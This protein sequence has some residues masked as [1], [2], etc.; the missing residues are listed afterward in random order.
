MPRFRFPVK[1]EDAYRLLVSCY[2]VEVDRRG[3]DFIQK[4]FT[5]QKIWEMAQYLT[6]ERPKFGALMCG[7]VGNGKTTLLYAFQSALNFLK[8]RGLFDDRE[9]KRELGMLIHSAKDIAIYAKNDWDKYERI[10]NCYMLGLDELGAEAKEVRDYGDILT[11]IIDLIEYRYVHQ[12]FTLITSNL[13]PTEI[14]DRYEERV[15]DRLREMVTY[16]IF[17][18]QESFRK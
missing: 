10:R 7:S 16:I 12:R 5:L 8:D 11:P 3:H 18:D 2:A 9:D 13:D 6:S 17:G 4:E 1:P 15:A 14:A